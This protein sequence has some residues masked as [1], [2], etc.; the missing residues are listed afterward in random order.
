MHMPGFTADAALRRTTRFYR[1]SVPSPA[2]ASRTSVAPQQESLGDCQNGCEIILDGCSIFAFYVP[3]PYSLVADAVCLGSYG[4]CMWSC[5][6]PASQPPG[7]V[8]V[9]SGPAC[10]GVERCDAKTG[11]CTCSNPCK[12]NERPQ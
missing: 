9:V 11:H 5:S 1:T 7:G 8:G 6:Q 4:L 2:I 3:W 12:G 10:C